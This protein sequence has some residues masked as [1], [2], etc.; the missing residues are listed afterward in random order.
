MVSRKAGPS[1][2]LG[3]RIPMRANRFLRSHIPPPMHFYTLSARSY[4]TSRNFCYVLT[5]PVAINL[6]RFR[7]FGERRLVRMRAVPPARVCSFTHPLCS[8]RQFADI[9]GLGTWQGLCDSVCLPLSCA[10]RMAAAAGTSGERIDV[11]DVVEQKAPSIFYVL[12]LLVRGMYFI[13]PYMSTFLRL[14]GC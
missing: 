7:D 8:R 14:L 2:L 11:E 1:W 12:S 6:I 5:I 3:R 4:T 13:I 10:Q 9:P